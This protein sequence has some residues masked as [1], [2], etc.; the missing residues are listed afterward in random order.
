MAFVLKN[1][2]NHSSSGS[3]PRL[4]TYDAG[5]DTTDTMQATGYF[6]NAATLLTVGSIIM[7]ITA[8]G[9]ATYRVTANA[10][11]VV[12]IAGETGNVSDRAVTAT[13]DGLTT[14][15]L[16]LTDNFVTVTSANANNIIM[17]PA[18]DASYVGKT[19]RGWIGANGCEVRAFGT[20]AK[21]NNLDC[22]TT[23]EAA[24]AATGMFTAVLIEAESWIL[25][26]LTELGA[27]T[28]IVPDA[29]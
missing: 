22:K 9:L 20:A 10:S 23:N 28:T 16:A 14:G 1:L 19:I 2:E 11:G 12:T 7:A 3:G 15:L 25:T 29:V 17:L 27:P 5:S 26:Y 18:A 6:N 4:F 13:S 24:L 21:I 8:T